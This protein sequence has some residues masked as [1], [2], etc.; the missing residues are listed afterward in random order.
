MR[1]KKAPARKQ[2]DFVHCR[3][4]AIY[5][6]LTAAERAEL[7]AAAERIADHDRQ[8]LSDSFPTSTELPKTAE[9]KRGDS[10]YT[11]VKG[12]L[13]V[14]VSDEVT[15]TPRGKV[16][17]NKFFHVQIRCPNLNCQSLFYVQKMRLGRKT[18]CPFCGQ[19]VIVKS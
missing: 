15:R 12:K 11:V 19:H 3:I 9:V 5:A 7:L 18:A 10:N 2:S 14:E 8:E 4:E 1:E 6:G 16:G 13:L 17:G